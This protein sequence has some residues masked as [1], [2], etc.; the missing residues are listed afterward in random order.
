MV[1]M[2]TKNI[3][4]N[5][6]TKS[7]KMIVTTKNIHI[8]THETHKQHESSKEFELSETISSHSNFSLPRFR[9][10]SPETMGV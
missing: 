2:A 9:G 6:K 7:V 3:K 10:V 5:L 8:K 1:N 4:M